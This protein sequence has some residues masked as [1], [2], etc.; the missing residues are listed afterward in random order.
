MFLVPRFVILFLANLAK[1]IIKR[2][3]WLFGFEAWVDFSVEGLK[4]STLNHSI[5][6]LIG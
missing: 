1:V 6:A 4:C 5:S 2:D 3:F